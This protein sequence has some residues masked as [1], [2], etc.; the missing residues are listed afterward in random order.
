MDANSQGSNV[1]RGKDK[2][3]QKK[4]EEEVVID[5]LLEMSIDQQL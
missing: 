5:C 3:F 2:H 4:K 1:G